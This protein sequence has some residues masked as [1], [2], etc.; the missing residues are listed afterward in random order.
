MTFIPGLPHPDGVIRRF[1]QFTGVVETV[2]VAASIGDTSLVVSDGSVFSVNDSLAIL[3]AGIEE[4]SYP[5]VTAISVDTLTLDRPLDHDYTTSATVEALMLNLNLVGSLSTPVVGRIRPPAGKLFVLTTIIATMLD[6]T[7]MDD[8]KY[9]GIDALVNGTIVRIKE[10][11]NT[12]TFANFKTN[13]DLA[14]VAFNLD[15]SD[16]APAGSFGL[17][18]SLNI[19][20][21]GL[22]G[23]YLNG[24]D[25]DE[26]QVLIQ[27]DLSGLQEHFWSAMGVVLDL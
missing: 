10:N 24:N 11:G 13:S 21:G 15:Y 17:R 2:A 19:S 5:L 6:G 1:A 14:V 23:H 25:G 26:M 4:K 27:D 12:N 16:K 7:A 20:Q 18:M 8:G 9:G 3:E 22:F